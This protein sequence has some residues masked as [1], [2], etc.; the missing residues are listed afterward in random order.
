M[1]RVSVVPLLLASAAAETPRAD[2]A[3]CSLEEEDDDGVGLLQSSSRNAH[4]QTPPPTSPV[5]PVHMGES[6]P[7]SRL[8]A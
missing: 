5:P 8:N 2:R 4:E 6:P 3:G 7:R 1:V